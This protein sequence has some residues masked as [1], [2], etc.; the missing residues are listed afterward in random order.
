MLQAS[1]VQPLLLTARVTSGC[2]MTCVR[3]YSSPAAAFIRH[4]KLL[5]PAVSHPGPRDYGNDANDHPY[6]GD[7]RRSASG[8]P[9]LRSLSVTGAAL[10]CLESAS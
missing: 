5:M 6:A 10:A 7:R 4:G 2:G 3:S 1:R 9:G 8:V